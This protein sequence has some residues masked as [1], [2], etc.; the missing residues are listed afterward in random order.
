[1][2]SESVE[3]IRE[4]RLRAGQQTFRLGDIADVRRGL[5]DP[6]AAKTRY[7]GREAVLLGTTMAPG[8]NVT[9]VGAAVEQTLKRIEQDLPVGV[10][11]GR[12]SDQAQVV[13]KSIHEFLEA[14]A[15]AIGI[16]LVVSLL[17]LGWRAGLVVALTIP[18]VLAATFFVMSVM[19]IDLQ[20]I[21]LGAL[22]IALGL[23]V[24]DAMIAVEM[25]DR[26]LEE[27]HDKLSAATFAYTS[28]AFPMLTGTL[29]TVAGFIPVG[30]AQ[31]QAGEYVSTLFWVT[32]IAL[33]ISWFA[34][35]YFTPWIGYRL[36]KVRKVKASDHHGAFDSRPYRAIRAVVAWCVRR[37]GTVVALTFAVLVAS[38]ASFAFIPK[39]F[40]PTSN[41]PEI[42]VD[43]WL[44][45]GSSFKET[46]NEAK[47]LEQRLLQDPD[48][49]Y[50]VNFIGEGAPR[51]YLPLDQQL[52]NQ[53]FAQLLLMSKSL[54]ARERVLDPRARHAGAG[55]PE[56]TLQGG[57]A[58]QRPAGRLARAGAR[59][60]PRSARGAPPGRRGGRGDAR[61]AG[62][63]QRARRLAGAGAE[64]EARHRS[65]PRP[66]PG[67]HLADGAPL[68]A[69]HAFRFP[70]RRVP[71]QR[72]DRQGDAA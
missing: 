67:S 18:M 54:E 21:S 65:G 68:P 6:P 46:E 24:D 43:L 66:C 52:K 19:G 11:L 10:E 26:K 15:E 60:G 42:L 16:V 25:M 62:A 22:I 40:F 3:D 36:L 61:N 64:L 63:Q 28:T 13:G 47:R 17:A 55:L 33:M 38:A 32:G 70:D 1:M 56:R 59:D 9:E 44:P 8:A 37:R 30:F 23:L 29:I 58:V 4:L 39:Q 57:S 20:R 27:G 5:E 71:R 14:L 12:I 35:V 72:R 51:F 49:A 45:E 48:L 69:G 7:Q 2:G 50:V 34:A 31:S 41:R 53:N